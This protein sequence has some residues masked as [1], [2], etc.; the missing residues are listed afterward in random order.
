MMA[1]ATF[2]DLLDD[3]RRV[4]VVSHLFSLLLKQLFWQNQQQRS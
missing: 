2:L 4:V 1:V 3:D